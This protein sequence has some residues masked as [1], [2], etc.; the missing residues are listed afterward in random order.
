MGALPGLLPALP[1]GSIQANAAGANV[2]QL[3]PNILP[4]Q[5]QILNLPSNSLNPPQLTRIVITGCKVEISWE[6]KSDNETGFAI[7]R[8]QVPNEP[9]AKIV[10]VVGANETSFEDTV[11]I[12]ADYQYSVEALGALSAIPQNQVNIQQNQQVM[13]AARSAPATRTVLPGANCIAAPGAMKHIYFEIEQLR[14]K[15]PNYIGAALWYS[16]N[17]STPRRVPSN[18]GA[19]NPADG[20]NF[21][22]KAYVPLPTS[23]YLNPDQPIVVRIWAA[24]HTRDSWE[25]DAPGPIELGVSVSSHAIKDITPSIGNVFY[26]FSFGNSSFSGVYLIAITDFVYG[27]AYS[28]AQ[29]PAPTNLKLA[30]NPIHNFRNLTWEWNGDPNKLDG[31]MIYRSY[32]CLGQETE[33]R[34]PAF[35]GKA[36]KGFSIPKIYEPQGCGYSYRVSALSKLGESKLSEPLTGMTEDTFGI[37][38]L[39]FKDI[40]IKDMEGDAHS[41]SIRLQAGYM[42]R[43]SNPM[44]LENGTYTGA[45]LYM[46]GKSPNDTFTVVLSPE[47]S[48]NVAFSVYGS[49]AGKS[50]QSDICG[51]AIVISPADWTKNKYE[52]T[53]TSNDGSCEAT[54]E[55]TSVPPAAGA[56]GQRVRAQADLEIRNLA[57]IGNKIYINLYNNGPQDLQSIYINIQQS[58][59]YVC[60][61]KNLYSTDLSLMD[62]F[63]KDFMVDI[64]A[65]SSIWLYFSKYFDDKAAENRYGPGPSSGVCFPFANVYVGPVIRSSNLTDVDYIETDPKNNTFRIPIAEIDSMP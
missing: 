17:N 53:L 7:Y 23:L 14:V 60:D 27:G 35:T 25:G 2:G 19:Y 31:Y 40:T 33:V 61:I 65:G 10:G 28:G 44:W 1:P 42:S 43:K 22:G 58:R 16:I 21:T 29:L 49:Y 30:E 52:H 48:L 45:S 39:T 13:Y 20:K 56:S 34:A 41:G 55:L 62:P 57:Y 18:E 38:Y 51:K 46:D 5:K 37:V 12:P 15:D 24:A 3:L 59:G 9:T 50:Y 6:D 64:K 4:D 54:V 26:P 63:L 36:L 47:E 11:P 32:S 8:R